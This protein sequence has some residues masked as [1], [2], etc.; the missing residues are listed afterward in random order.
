M[1]QAS[2]SENK[3]MCLNANTDHL[4]KPNLNAAGL[5]S[6]LRDP[7]ASTGT[8]VQRGSMVWHCTPIRPHSIRRPFLLQAFGLGMRFILTG[9]QP[10][11]YKK[12]I[13]ALNA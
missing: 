10:L 11:R 4:T 3:L 9:E 1:H 8:R 12:H 2:Q 7:K 13:Y 5:P 6:M